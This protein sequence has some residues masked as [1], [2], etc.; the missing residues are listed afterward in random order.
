MYVQL[1]YLHSN[2]EVLQDA[3][4]HKQVSTPQN[5][6]CTQ[7]SVQSSSQPSHVVTSMDLGMDNLKQTLIAQD[8]LPPAAIDGSMCIN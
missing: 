8:E 6:K 5:Q 1:Y 2:P 4:T 7:P 3:S